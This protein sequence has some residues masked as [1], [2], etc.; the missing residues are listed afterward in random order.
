MDKQHITRLKELARVKRIKEATN[1]D[2]NISLL[3][4]SLND[5]E[6]FLKSEETTTQ[7]Y[8]RTSEWPKSYENL[9]SPPSHHDWEDARLQKLQE[10]EVLTFFRKGANYGRYYYD[11]QPQTKCPSTRFIDSDRNISESLEEI[12]HP[13]NTNVSIKSSAPPT[14]TKKA[15]I[16][17]T[18]YTQNKINYKAQPF[19]SKIEPL[20]TFDSINLNHINQ[21]I[22]KHKRVFECDICS[23]S[24]AKKGGVQRHIRSIH[25]KTVQICHLC[26]KTF[27]RADSLKRHL[28]S[29]HCESDSSFTCQ[30]CSYNTS[31]KDNLTRHVRVHHQNQMSLISN[32]KTSKITKDFILCQ[33]QGNSWC[34]MNTKRLLIQ[35]DFKNLYAL[36]NS[37][38]YITYV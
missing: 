2:K 26:D 1:T 36:N 14:F 19:I 20:P 17:N 18:T 10:S 16:S 25:F 35:N 34:D 12:N 37:V 38:K 31:R 21:M 8:S 28:L 29:C 13:E 7:F 9:F 33:E 11:P 23:K 22:T 6:V 3:N 24:F 30:H 32:Q 5:F 27:M 15:I 4:R